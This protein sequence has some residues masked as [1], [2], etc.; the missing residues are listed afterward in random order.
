MAFSFS[1]EF[2]KT[3]RYTISNVERQVF[4]PNN[5]PGRGSEPRQAGWD[6]LIKAAEG[7]SKH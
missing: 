2:R 1:S 6:G 5:V 4:T 3:Q 7:F